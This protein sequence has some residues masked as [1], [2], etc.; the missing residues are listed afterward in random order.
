MDDVLKQ[1]IQIYSSKD[2]IELEARF[3]VRYPVTRIDFDHIIQKLKSLGWNAQFPDGTYHLNI[4]NEYLNNKI[5]KT[6]ISNIRTQIKGLNNIKQYCLNSKL[7]LNK[8][9]TTFYQKKVYF[10]MVVE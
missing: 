4:N 7:S 5:N 1:F 6:A 10:P 3:G 9:H 8:E 2:N